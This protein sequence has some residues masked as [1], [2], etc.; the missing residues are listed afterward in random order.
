LTR[1]GSELYW[2]NPAS[3]ELSYVALERTTA[4]S[5]AEPGKPVSK[6][7]GGLKGKLYVG[8]SFS[9]HIEWL[10]PGSEC[11]Y[12]ALVLVR[13]ENIPLA[14]EEAE[15]ELVKIAESLHSVGQSDNS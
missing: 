1:R 12:L 10:L 11:N 14:T 6:E 5:L 9:L 2:D 7:I 3:N 4:V 15:R 13:P 8:P